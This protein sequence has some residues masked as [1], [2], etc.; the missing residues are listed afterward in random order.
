MH[1]RHPSHRQPHTSFPARC[2]WLV[3]LAINSFSCQLCQLS[4]ILDDKCDGANDT[5]WARNA[6]EN[7][8]SEADTIKK[9]N[10]GC[11]ED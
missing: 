5:Y 9:K 6:V 7:L 10:F 1:K 11:F 4:M 3:L 8:T 2:L